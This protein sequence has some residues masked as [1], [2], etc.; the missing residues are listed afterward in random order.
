MIKLRSKVK[1]LEH[2]DK[3]GRISTRVDHISG[4]SAYT[5]RYLD[6]KGEQQIAAGHEWE[7]DVLDDSEGIEDPGAPVYE[8][9]TQVTVMGGEIEG[10]VTGIIYSS[11]GCIEYEVSYVN[12]DGELMRQRIEEPLLTAIPDAEPVATGSQTGS[13]LYT[14]APR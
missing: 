3:E 9:G 14:P 10:V 6:D 1:M 12:A 8:N 4:Y 13:N 2:G 5:V 11:S 7:F